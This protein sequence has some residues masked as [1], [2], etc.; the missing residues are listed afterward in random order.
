MTPHVNTDAIPSKH[1]LISFDLM[2]ALKYQKLII[3]YY[4]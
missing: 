2:L 4:Y 1:I 3:A